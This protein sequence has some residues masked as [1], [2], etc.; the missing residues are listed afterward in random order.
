MVPARPPSLVYR[1]GLILV[2]LAMV[3]LPVIYVALTALVIWEI[4]EFAVYD[5]LAIWNWPVGNS[6]YGLLAKFF[7]SV[8]PLLV[9][10]IVAFFMVKPLFARRAARMHPLAMNPEIEPRV[11]QLVQDVC[12]LLDAPSPQRIELDCAVNASAAFDGGLRGFFTNKLVLTIGLPLVAGLT[13][14]E[15]A[16][17]VAH[18]FGHFRQGAGMR[19]SFVIRRINGWFSRV[20]YE[21]DSWDEMIEAWAASSEGWMS[22]MVSCIQFGVWISRRVL[23]ILMMVGHLLGAFLLR[24]MEYDADAAEIRLAGSAA[25]ESTTLKMAMLGT[26]YSELHFE[27]RRSW[28]SKFKLPDNLPLLVEH[29][30]AA[31]PEEKRERIHN[32]VGLAKTGWLDT[33]PSSADR[34]RNARRLAEPGFEISNEPARQ[35]FENF[36]TVSHLVT[37]AY[38][39]DD[40]N[41]PTADDFLIP[42][43]QIMAGE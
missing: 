25:F 40:L 5:F 30:A 3:C 19:A 1:I 42:V 16:G 22:L 11:Y 6:K 24:Q 26:V 41:I 32:A 23:W 13:V 12:R 36:E 20:I 14:R 37:L 2:A 28:R 4:Y 9:G 29:R 31:M 8:T 27:M 15:L 21:R 18:E 43:R 35:L 33:H 10:G 34:V 39:E 7:C 17:V 38:Y